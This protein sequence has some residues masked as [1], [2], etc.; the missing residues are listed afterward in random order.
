MNKIN[1]L[2][3]AI[4]IYGLHQIIDLDTNL[5]HELLSWFKASSYSINYYNRCA[6]IPAL[7][8][9]FNI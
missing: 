4:K 7:D 8:N 2:K 6:F 3:E 1:S 5:G 9:N